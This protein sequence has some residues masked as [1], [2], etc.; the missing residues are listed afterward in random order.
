[1]TDAAHDADQKCMS[2]PNVIDRTARRIVWRRQG[3]LDEG[4]LT[5][6]DN[7]E[8]REF[9][10][11]GEGS[12]AATIEIRDPCFYRQ[13]VFGGSLGA[14]EA[15]IRGSWTCDDLVTLVGIFCRNAT[16]ARLRDALPAADGQVFQDEHRGLIGQHRGGALLDN[17]ATARGMTA[18]QV[19]QRFR[20][21]RTGVS[22]TIHLARSPSAPL[23]SIKNCSESNRVPTGPRKDAVLSI[24]D[25]LDECR[26]ARVGWG[27]VRRWSVPLRLRPVACRLSRLRIVRALIVSCPRVVEHRCAARA[28]IWYCCWPWC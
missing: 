21:L 6:A 15:F 11:S 13:L 25:H 24:L 16:A 1:M 26:A 17:P 18:R 27:V 10:R 7:G 12:L 2:K 3:S 22:R 28:G 8:R 20:S 14:A 23:D 19:S 4:R 9:G 5:I